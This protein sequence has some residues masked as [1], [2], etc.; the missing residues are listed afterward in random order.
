MSHPSAP[1]LC[2]RGVGDDASALRDDY[3]GAMFESAELRHVVAPATYA[4][5]V[6]KLREALLAAQAE[7]LERK[8]FP[9]VLLIS[10][11]EGA[12]KGDALHVLHEWMDPRH[13]RASAFDEPDCVEEEHPSMWRFWQALPPA[14]TTAVF[15]GAWYATTLLRRETLWARDRPPFPAPAIWDFA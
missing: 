9:V 14:G 10:G 7:V 6:P 13:V 5:A 3:A 11:V 1:P 15:L 8:A 12:G 4:R 2:R